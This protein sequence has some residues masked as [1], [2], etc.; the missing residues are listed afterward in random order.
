MKPCLLKSV[1]DTVLVRRKLK[2]ASY[3]RHFIRFLD[4]LYVTLAIQTKPTAPVINHPAVWTTALLFT[5]YII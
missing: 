3:R 2:L 4:I 5:K 1:F